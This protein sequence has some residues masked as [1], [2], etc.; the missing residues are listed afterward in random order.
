MGQS[1]IERNAI[2]I[3]DDVELNRAI[4]AELFH[5]SYTILEAANGVDAIE[6]LRVHRGQIVIMLLD[7]IMPLMDGYEV[8][9][10]MSDE[11]WLSQ[12]PVVLITS[13]SSESASLRSYE[14]GASDIINKPFN[15]SI[16]KRRV[17][18]VIELYQHKTH[19]ERVIR[20]QIAV[21]ELQARQI[22]QTNTFIVDALSS[23]VEFRSCES[24]QHI[25]HV[26]TITEMLLEGLMASYPQYCLTSH[27]ITKISI[28]S[29][30][31]DIGKIAIPEHVLKKPSHLTPEEFEIMK[32]HS[33]KGSEILQ[34]LQ[35]NHSENYYRYSH[36][37]CLYHHERWDGGGYP[38]GL[39]GSQIPIWA[40]AVSL[41]DA[42]DSLT[43]SRIYREAFSHEQSLAMIFNGECG[44]FNPDLIEV[45]QRVASKLNSDGKPSLLVAEPSLPTL[46]FPP[47]PKQAVLPSDDLA[48][49]AQ[50]L[51]DRTLWLLERER[52]KNRIVTEL[53]G[54]I[55]FN[56]DAV[57]DEIE[58]SE[59]FH[60]IF[61]GDTH[62][63]DAQ[64]ALRSTKLLVD[65]SNPILSTCMS[66]LT[67]ESPR[68]SFDVLLR[69]A[70]GAEEWF[71]V[72]AHALWDPSGEGRC[73]GLI[74]KLVNIHQRKMAESL[75]KYEASTDAL[76][77]LHNR[78]SFEK[79]AR[80]MLHD[81][82]QSKQDIK[83]ALLFLDIDNFKLVNDTF[84]HE[85]GDIVLRNVANTL[86]RT[87][88][89]SDLVGRLGG[90]EFVAC[91]G[92]ITSIEDVARK[93]ENICIAC[94][95]TGSSSPCPENGPCGNDSW[96][97]SCSVG[98]AMYPADGI[99]YD[100]LMRRADVALYN[101][102]GRG[103]NCF[104]FY[105]PSM[106]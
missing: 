15:P 13:E 31:H 74:G 3:V 56:Y 82:A 103:K 90:D 12:L 57:S 46:L 102:K 41:A 60:E 99:D 17:G 4:L 91:L 77:G 105:E 53:S 37:I 51:S 75:L 11:Q 79:H 5:D 2:L 34:N 36:D 6:V 93:V 84:G 68:T 1:T 23:V 47:S 92:H 88:R 28:A 89:E 81:V 58:F 50:I 80:A 32:T 76:T 95:H 97:V 18:N 96:Q 62:I 106:A 21:L 100:T 26:R 101:S 49:N 83:C 7:I 94:E 69:T 87:L 61:Q 44:V 64:N 39:V 33:L 45:F 71:E 72:Y 67:P 54:D 14:L 70:S 35:A 86:R 27:S 42:Y 52:E 66:T 48:R 24:A 25:R 30:M 20:S 63:S 59:K 19:Q 10:V 22:S 40:Q 29:A 98:I 38:D 104:T 78:K 65:T 85:T 55:V 73:V 43:S 16:V 9:Q 8:L